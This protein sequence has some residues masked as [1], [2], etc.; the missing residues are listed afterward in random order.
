MPVD[1]FLSGEKR[2][3]TVD[4]YRRLDYNIMENGLFYLAKNRNLIESLYSNK[5][6]SIILNESLNLLSK[7]WFTPRQFIKMANIQYLAQADAAN[8]NLLNDSID[9]H[10]STK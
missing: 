8:T 6:N 7:Y 10:I 4:L 9:Y 5:T 3:V 2:A 1:F